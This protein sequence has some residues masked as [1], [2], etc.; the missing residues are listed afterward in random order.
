MLKK[1][2]VTNF[3]NFE[4][5]IVF[6]LTASNGY[7]FN[8][9]CIKNGIVNNCMIYGYNGCGK[10]NLGLA[11]FDIVGHLSNKHREMMRYNNYLNA[12]S[13]DTVAKFHYEFL[14]G[15]QSVCY[16]YTKTDYLT[17]KSEILRINGRE[18]VLFDRNNGN[19]TFTSA[20]VGTETL[21]RV[22]TDS[23]L[24]V[25][26]YIRSNTTLPPNDENYAFL[27]LFSFVENMLFFRSLEDRIFIGQNAPNSTI[28]GEIIR[29]N[30]VK[31]FE[32][33]LN[34]GNVK[35]KLAVVNTLGGP[36]LAFVFGH[37]KIL[38]TSAMST[39]TGAM[40]LF[41]CW[42]LLIRDAQVSF[43]FIDEFD[44][45]YHNDL[46]KLVIKK[47]M[48]SGIQF[49]VTTH[50]TSL[51]SNSLMRPDCYYLIGNNKMLPLSKCTDKELREVHNIEKIYKAGGF[52][53]G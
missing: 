37:K 24:S 47:L 33:F 38:F 2:S 8:P 6:D 44:A 51:M 43:V 16:E 19:T 35:C 4:T 50:N 15:G 22:I 40:M 20:L 48:Q 31:E 29:R 12:N 30:A 36:D 1:F 14:L 42:Y 7:A 27:L 10:S 32:E 18:V 39:G 5:E 13:H 52:Y 3:K 45:F 25:L 53:V 46:A 17:L 49:I 21:N 23:S 26:K 34:E 9:D 28:T 11:I 41:F